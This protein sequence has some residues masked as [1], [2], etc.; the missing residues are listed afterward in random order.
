MKVL[1]TKR[2]MKLPANNGTGESFL[3]FYLDGQLVYDLKFRL[4]PGNPEFYA[5]ADVSQYIGKTVELKNDPET[6]PDECL[7]FE[8]IDRVD[9]DALYGEPYRPKVHY[10]VPTGHNNDP[11]GLVY[12]K[13]RYHLFCQYNPCGTDWGN[14]HWY[15]AS[16]PDLVH[17]TNHGMALYPDKYGMIYSG[18]GIV[19]EKNV[20]GLGTPEDPAMIVFYTGAAGRTKL[21]PVRYADQRMAY[22]HDG[23]HFTKFEGNPVIANIESY[24]RDPKVVFVSEIDRYVM[25]LYLTEDRYQLLTSP[26]L[27]HWEQL[28]QYRIH[29]NENECPDIFPLNYNGKKYWVLMGAH[30]YY[31]VGHFEKDGSSV[32]FVKDY[33]AKKLSYGKVPYATQSYPNDP[34]GRVIRIA[35]DRL[36]IKSVL[37]DHQMGVPT[38]MGLTDVNGE[39]YLTALPVKEF[40]SLRTSTETFSN[41]DFGKPFEYTTVSPVDIEISGKIDAAASF[42]LD[43]FG[44]KATVDMALN[45]ITLSHPEGS[46]SPLS[47]SCR[48]LDM[49]IIADVH[50]VEFYLDEGRIFFASPYFSGRSGGKISVSSSSDGYVL[51]SLTV[52]NLEEIKPDCSQI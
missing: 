7:V 47:V 44:L 15:H 1:I 46:S 2:Y 29:E 51:D 11:N 16:T 20:T 32:S 5:Y 39:P 36:Q 24:N 21:A 35:W 25:A 14:M 43:I 8:Q 31:I 37:I 23:I 17:W 3:L 52:H 12:Y 45:T 33:D 6:V 10:S 38:E 22:S 28:T 26:D 9:A 19:D 27:I 34:N 30:D 42:T 18:S 13:G 40:E 50:S 48:N 4:N 49:R 41:I